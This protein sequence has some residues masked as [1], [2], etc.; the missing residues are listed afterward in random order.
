MAL[1]DPQTISSVALPRTGAG[2]NVGEFRA[3]DGT[4]ILRVEHAYGRRTRRLAKYTVSKVTSD[5]LV[6]SQNTKASMAVYIVA[7]VPVNGYTATEQKA[8]VDAFVAYLAAGS[9]SVV[10]KFLGGES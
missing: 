10:S 1:S 8:V 2:A 6:P 3:A 7:D 4:A 9:G 5:P